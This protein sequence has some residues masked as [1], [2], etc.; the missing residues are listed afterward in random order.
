MGNNRQL[1]FP[2]WRD[3]ILNS[4][5]QI[6][7]SENKLFAILLLC[8]TLFDIKLGILGLVAAILINI[9]AKVIGLN[10]HA[11]QKGV[12]GFNA[13]L[14]GIGLGYR[15]EFGL[16][17][18]ILFVFAILL[19]LVLTVWING[20]FEK[21]KLP[22]LVFP[23]LLTYWMIQLSGDSFKYIHLDESQVYIV[24]TI[25]KNQTSSWYNFVHQLDNLKLPNS[26]IVY[27]KTLTGIFFQSS[28]LGG[29]LISIGLLIASR[30]AFTLSLLGF[31]SAYTFFKLLGADLL[32]MNY[33]LVGSNFIFMAIAI[34]GFFTIPNIYSYLSVII[35]TPLLMFIL[36]FSQ[37]VIEL[38]DLNSYTLSF[39]ITVTIFIY[40]LQQRWLQK[41]LHIVNLHHEPIEKTVYKYLNTA[42]RFKNLNPI[43][44]YL[45]FWGK[46][47]VSQG[48]NGEITHLGDWSKALDFV[49]AD[50]KNKTYQKSGTEKNDFYCYNKPI[51][52][53][54]DAYIYD[55]LNT[56]DENDIS[57]VNTEKNWGNTIILN[58][59]N[60][61]FS[62]ISHIKKD[63]FQVKIGDY[64]TKGTTLAT[65][66]NSGRSPEP[67]IHFQ[68]QTTPKIG[69]KPIDYPIAYFMEH[70]GNDKILKIEEVPLEGKSI[71]N[72]ETTP[73][74]QN[75][76]DFKPG[77][78]L[79][80]LVNNRE[81]IEWKILSDA[82]NRLYLYCEKQH[83][84]A[85]FVNDSTLFY[86]YE[87]EGD[88]N[89]Y[90]FL[91]YCSF[92]KVLLGYYSNHLL[93]DEM[94]QIYFNN[95]ITQFIQ[96]FCAPF[97]LFTKAKYSFHF[98]SVDSEIAPS[99]INAVSN[100]DAITF[101]KKTRKINTTIVIKNNVIANF[102]IF[103][104]AKTI[105][106]E[107][108]K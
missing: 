106:F 87:F 60:G 86:F 74:L 81:E 97:F 89:S 35:A 83:S 27:L 77:K 22:F 73:I 49:I 9:F 44:M 56:V 28:I 45:P 98:K 16:A 95:K 51:L 62:Q 102:T 3:T 13:V 79:K 90:L 7:F 71:S 40:F 108:I 23:F 69:E 17:F 94:P 92:Y 80:Y 54:Q 43:K 55:I 58:H 48:Y 18:S 93:E 107:C 66:G 104:S 1:Q 26:L 12:Y 59:L 4:Y 32:F 5:S 34:G 100:I 70:N 88:K 67:H 85:Y 41:Y 21:K 52:A 29:I 19:L 11:I 39:C 10:F 53:P 103:K 2:F 63:S 76:F 33:H 84:Y 91:F 20:F 31:I 82:N 105:T 8:V 64:V 65:C 25:A 78:T 68:V 46:W 99:E 75:A 36:F 72:V 14:L 6:F 15:Y 30:I 50:E 38:Y 24:N 42:Q 61:L 96:D 47:N 101:S 57:D 37:K